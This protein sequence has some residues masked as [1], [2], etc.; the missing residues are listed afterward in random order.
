MNKSIS[1][2]D[3]KH[4][5]WSCPTDDLIDEMRCLIIVFANRAS[6]MLSD[7]ELAKAKK[8]FENCSKAPL[9]CVPNETAY[10]A[11]HI[12]DILDWVCFLNMRSVELDSKTLEES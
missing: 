9:F 11:W 8:D 7:S 2:E 4:F 3:I 1:R 12:R 6:A 5:I 10:E